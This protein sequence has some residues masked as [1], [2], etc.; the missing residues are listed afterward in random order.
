[1]KTFILRV[2]LWLVFAGVV[3]IVCIIDK[4]DMIKNGTLKYTG[5]A[6]IVLAI[7]T[8]IIMV[9]LGYYLKLMKWSMTKQ[10]ISG[11][12]NVM[13]PLCL[14]F[15]GAGLIASNI[16]NIRYILVVSIFSEAVAIPINPFP[17]WVYER[18]IS[19]LKEA[20]K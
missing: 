11:I 2:I 5:W 1:M 7:I 14:L 17:K 10:I 6:I 19:D 3:P 13:I 16:E 4:Y 18:N 15:V 20:L 9:V 8:I 12:R